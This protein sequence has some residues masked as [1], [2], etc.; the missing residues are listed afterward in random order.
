[1]EQFSERDRHYMSRALALAKRGCYTVGANPMV[2]CV[3]VRDDKIIAEDY[4]RRTGEAHAE[5]LALADAAGDANSATVYVTLEP[6]VHQGRTA[7]CVPALIEA[8]VK[9]VVMA[10]QDPNPLV[11]GRGV[12]ELKAAGMQV[13]EGLFAEQARD[14]NRGFI[15]RI[16]RGRPWLR[17]KSAISLDGHIALGSGKSAWISSE[18]A[19]RDVQFWRARSS[20]LL[21]SSRT[22]CADDPQLNVRLEAETLGMEG[23]VRQPLRIVLDSQLSTSPAA[24]IYHSDAKS[25]VVCCDSAVSKVRCSEFEQRGV[26]VLSIKTVKSRIPLLELLE[27]LAE[28]YEVNE[29]Q[30]EAGGVLLG[31]I[32]DAD[33]CD[34]LLLYIAPCL[35]GAG[36]KKLAEFDEMIQTMEERINFSYKEVMNVGKDIRVLL[37]PCPR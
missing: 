28:R 36:S 19:R 37:E 7:P 10:M 2:G 20:A 26:E 8:K 22:V 4:H 15:S 32:I 3:I 24:R 29:I 6:C 30:V 14:L 33:L 12:S 21:T 27:I 18:E 23:A 16:E 9:R 1:M 5:A 31:A 13:E 25:I 35:L 11:H 34:E 17:L